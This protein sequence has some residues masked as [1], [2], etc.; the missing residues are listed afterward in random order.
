MMRPSIAAAPRSVNSNQ[1]K[2]LVAK[3]MLE[4]T[5][6]IGLRGPHMQELLEN[7]PDVGWLEV[8]S[9]NFFGHGGAP[10]HNLLRA[11]EDYPIS[12]HGV[13]LSIGSGDSLDAMHLARL[14]HL[15]QM[16]EP[17]FV[18][19]HLSWG[20]INGVHFNDLLPL[21]YTEEALDHFC[22]HVR[23]VQDY[24]G[25][26]ILIENPSS[27]LRYRHS[28]IP[29]SEF[30]AAVSRRTGAGLLLD[31]NNVFVS[32]CNHR[33]DPLEYLADV[34]GELVDEIHLA[35]HTLKK[36]PDGEIR[37][38]DHASPVSDA[39]WSLYVET[40][41]LMGAKPTL[42][43]WDVELPPLDRLVAEADVA[44]RH[45]NALHESAA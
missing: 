25:R 1:A 27:Y 12:L 10:I 32:A 30:L 2:Q 39:V 35:G 15:V 8:H 3:G 33:F 28:T 7:R 42:I 22:L 19:E 20:S 24:L 21:P 34:P 29:E 14:A 17:V 11:R 31:V 44:G 45:L 38:D 16:V 26:K 41:K 40:L 4:A 43:E 18:S 23:Q 5:A 13:G 36:F 6:G 37:I 9:E